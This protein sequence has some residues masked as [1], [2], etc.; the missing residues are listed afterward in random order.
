MLAS[1]PLPHRV[2]S[3]SIPHLVTRTAR[4]LV[5][6]KSMNAIQGYY[7]VRP[8]DLFWRPSSLPAFTSGAFL[9]RSPKS[10]KSGRSVKPGYSRTRIAG[11]RPQLKRKRDRVQT[12]DMKHSIGFIGL[13]ILFAG[14][15]A[16]FPGHINVTD[17]SK[18]R[19]GMTRAEVI[20][21]LGKPEFHIA[22]DPEEKMSYV[23]NSQSWNGRPFEVRLVDGIVQSYGT[24][25]PDPAKAD[26]VALSFKPQVA[27]PWYSEEDYAQMVVLLPEEL[28][29]EAVPYEQWQ[30]ASAMEEDAIRSAGRV[31]VRVI[32]EP[33]EIETWCRHH[34]VP[35]SKE[36]ITAFTGMRLGLERGSSGVTTT[37]ASDIGRTGSA[38]G[39][40]ADTGP[41]K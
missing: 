39:S 29:Q 18:L 11:R 27:V 23:A 28:R 22:M 38:S 36:A 26:R 40:V 2:S 17:A 35:L 20:E 37:V 6:A 24:A 13:A 4:S 16:T 15:C 12:R 33:A 14:G 1:L 30:S 9:S 7:I 32:V 5:Y 21:T 41:K 31:P 10:L 8:D 25:E 34:E 3:V 19:P